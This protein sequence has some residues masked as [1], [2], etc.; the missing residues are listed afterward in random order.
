MTL[1]FTQKRLTWQANLREP[2]VPR[3]STQSKYRSCVAAPTPFA[4]Y[5]LRPDYYPRCCSNLPKR[6][7]PLTFAPPTNL[8]GCYCYLPG[9]HSLPYQNDTAILPKC[10]SSACEWIYLLCFFY[11]KK[12]NTCKIKFRFLLDKLK[13]LRNSFCL[14]PFLFSLL[15]YNFV[16]CFHFIMLFPFSFIN[17]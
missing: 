16:F 13:N 12:L 3:G 10:A 1:K 7:S 15:K 14:F 2:T 8:P 11:K 17:N 5:Q 6:H 9:S 4:K